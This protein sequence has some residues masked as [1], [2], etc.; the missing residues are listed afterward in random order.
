VSRLSQGPTFRSELRRG[1]DAFNLSVGLATSLAIGAGALVLTSRGLLP[2][3]LGRG[4]LAQ[5]LAVALASFLSITAFHAGLHAYFGWRLERGMRAA[6]EGQAA[7][8]VRLLGVL[9][10]KGM[11]HYDADGLARKALERSREGS[12]T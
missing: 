11:D 1:F 4:A 3:L 5:S 12:R 2:V 7:D 8:A 10:W 9:D 6:R